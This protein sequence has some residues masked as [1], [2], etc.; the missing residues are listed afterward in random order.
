VATKSA[1]NDRRSW[2]KRGVR[3]VIPY[4]AIY[5]GLALLVTIFQRKL[6]YHPTVLKPASA[7]ALA[8]DEGLRRWD[9]PAGQP[10]GWRRMA[11]SGTAKGSIMITHGNAGCAVQRGHYA[12]ALGA[13]GPLDIFILEYP[14]YGDRPG[15]PSER[16]LFAAAEEAF[17]LLPT[18][19]PVYLL[20]ESLGTGIAAHLAGGHPDRIAGMLLVA[21]YDRLGSVAQRQ[22]PI[23]PTRWM[24]L[25]P[26]R[27]DEALRSYHGPVA[28]LLATQDDVVPA[29]FGNR[30]FL[31]YQGPKRLWEVDGA[32]H[33]DLPDRPKEFWDEVFRFWDLDHK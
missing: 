7:D 9:N 20:G 33:N 17:G 16:T 12:E 27:S 15:A 21:P 13:A 24:L 22:M 25:D 28:V 29:K 32:G 3:R 1:A 5:L 14:G 10:I 19:S 18:N 26:Y 30:L 23:F 4:L 31:G 8:A 11:Q 2:I 6:I